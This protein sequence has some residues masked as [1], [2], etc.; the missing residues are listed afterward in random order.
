[1]GPRRHSNLKRSLGLSRDLLPP[2]LIEELRLRSPKLILLR[3]PEG[4]R[5]KCAMLAESLAAITGAKVIASADP[6]YGACDISPEDA[7]AVG[8]DLVV[9]IGHSP[10]GGCPR[11]GA[12]IIETMAEVDPSPL[13][14]EALKLLESERVI[15]LATTAQHIHQLDRIKKALEA[16]SKEVKIGRPSGWAAHEGQVLGCDY[17]AA[18]AV[19]DGVDAFLFFGGGRFHALGLGMVTDKRVVAAD[20]YEGRVLDLTEDSKR[21]LR[22]RC[23][24]I[25]AFKAVKRVGVLICLKGAQKRLREAWDLKALLERKGKEAIILSFRDLRAEDLLSFSELEA[26]A[27]TACPRIAI[28]DQPAV[29]KPMLNVREVMVAL[30]ELSW[31]DY[32]EDPFSQTKA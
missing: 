16:S 15:G 6:C 7:E 12:V 26:F 4:L 17:S 24:A 5:P 1:M 20:P 13:I 27:N 28:E 19:A 2:K 29:G 11:D 3:L 25:E 10:M 32:R 31:E 30:G 18:R 9:Q 21:L 8:A 14:D 22:A 23:A